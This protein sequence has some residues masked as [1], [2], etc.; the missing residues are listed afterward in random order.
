MNMNNS[1]LTTMYESI[2]TQ[3]YVFLALFRIFAFYHEKYFKQNLQKLFFYHKYEYLS[4]NTLIHCSRIIVVHIY[5]NVFSLK[6]TQ[7]VI[8]AQTESNQE[9]TKE[10]TDKHAAEYS[11]TVCWDVNLSV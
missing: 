1:Y 5:V 4:K 9:V 11:K 2:L 7:H 6:F 8:V 10:L 3:I